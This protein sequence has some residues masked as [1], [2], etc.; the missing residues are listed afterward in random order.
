MR[1]N[2]SEDNTVFSMDT[3]YPLLYS[4][5]R[6]GTNPTILH[7]SENIT[8]KVKYF[9]VRAYQPNSF[10]PEIQAYEYE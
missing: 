8:D 4:M 2:I 6:S 3:D 7:Q 5:S 1:A 9:N 10:D